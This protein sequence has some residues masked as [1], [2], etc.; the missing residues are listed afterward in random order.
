MGNHY[1]WG[2]GGKGEERTPEIQVD[3][4][5]WSSLGTGQPGGAFPNWALQSHGARGVLAHGLQTKE[6]LDMEL[7]GHV[8]TMHLLVP[9]SLSEPQD[10][11]TNEMQVKG[12]VSLPRWDI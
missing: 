6:P 5:L 9:L 3:D 1:S 2:I 11:S 7:P 12:H 10:L 4:C 8:T